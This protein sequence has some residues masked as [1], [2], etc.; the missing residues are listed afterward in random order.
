M[1]MCSVRQRPMPSAPN[2]RA[3]A[4][5]S[6]VSALVRTPSVRSSSA[7]PST[8]SNS[9][10]TS[11]SSSGTSSVVTTP[12]VPS[13]AIRSPSPSCVPFTRTVFAARSI[14]SADAPDTHGLPIPRATSAAWLA[15]PPSEVRMPL[16]AWKPGH[17][18]GLGERAHQDH[19]AA[20]LGRRHGLGGGEHD[21]ALGGARRG[22]DALG[23]HLELGVAGEGRVQQRVEPAGVDRRERPGLV[24]QPLLHGVDREAHRGLRRP[25]GVARLEHVEAALLHRELGVLHVAVVALERRRRISISS[26]WASGITLLHLVQVARRAHARHHVL[27]LGVRQEVAARPGRAG[28]LVAR[29]GDAGARGVALVAEHHLLHVHRRAPV[30]GDAVD[31]PVL[32]RAVAHPGVEHGADRLAQLLARVLREV[33]AGLRRGRAP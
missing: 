30:V 3:L 9:A 16:A 12:A 23:Q 10:L 29:E 25:L 24:E 27:A 5:S 8:V 21:R 26:A 15:L 20:V 7:Q 18:V 6:G 33:L 4:A 11:G 13:I 1:N 19:V 28:D 2:S 17:V 22:G 14:S 31:A 32:D